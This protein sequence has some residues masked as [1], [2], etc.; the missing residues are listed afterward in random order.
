MPPP[1]PAGRS[2]RPGTA[3]RDTAGT[4][5]RGWLRPPR[6]I[7]CSSAVTWRPA[8][9]PSATARSPT[10]SRCRCPGWPVPPGAAGRQKRRISALREAVAR[11]RG[12]RS[13]RGPQDDQAPRH[14]GDHRGLRCAQRQ[15]HR[16]DDGDLPPRRAARTQPSSTSPGSRVPRPLDRSAEAQQIIIQNACAASP[17]AESRGRRAP[18]ASVRQKE[19]ASDPRTRVPAAGRSRSCP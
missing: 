11:R 18:A 4:P 19:R 6:A 2:A 5:G 14:R 15:R 8:S 1:A 7:T 12:R 17:L 3:P 13:R 10:A 16:P 9:S